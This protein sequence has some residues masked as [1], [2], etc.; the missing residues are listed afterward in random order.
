MIRVFLVTFFLIINIQARENPFFPS[1]TDEDLTVTSNKE[2]QILSLERASITLPSSAR[3]IKRVTIEYE[4][5]DAS[6][7]KKSIDLDNL[8]DWHLPIFVSQSYTEQ[9]VQKTQMKKEVFNLVA[10]IEYAKFFISKKS[11]KIT[12]ED[13]ILRNFLLAKPHRI[14]MDFKRD[15]SVKTY[16]KKFQDSPFTKVRIGNH[17]GYYRVV[18]ELD[19]YYRYKLKKLS[20]GC[21]IT[22][23]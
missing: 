23:Q 18:I 4:N 19:G 20:D 3:I 22:L 2:Q 7:Q 13:K 8:I 17:N 14:V 11:L 10:E 1:Q 9:K 21:L 5:M 6:I 12:T 16:I 15:S